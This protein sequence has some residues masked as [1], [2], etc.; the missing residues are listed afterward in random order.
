MI[1]VLSEAKQKTNLPILFNPA[2]IC[3]VSNPLNSSK[4]NYNLTTVKVQQK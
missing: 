4:A 1:S 2:L 3:T